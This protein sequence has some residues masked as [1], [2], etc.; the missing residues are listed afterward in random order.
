MGCCCTFSFSIIGAD[1]A[2]VD[3]DDD[4]DDD[5]AN[6]LLNPRKADDAMISLYS[7]SERIKMCAMQRQQQILL[8]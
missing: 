8:L 7:C 6:D 2:D 4:D 5:D 1:N 3:V